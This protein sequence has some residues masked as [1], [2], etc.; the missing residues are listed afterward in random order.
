MN[1]GAVEAIAWTEMVAIG[2]KRTFAAPQHFGRYW[3]NS[4]QNSILAGA[5]LSANDPKRTFATQKE[6]SLPKMAAS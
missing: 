4:G 1:V 5:G 6:V 3:S 2:T